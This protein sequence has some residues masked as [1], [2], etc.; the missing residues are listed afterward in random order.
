MSDK[1]GRRGE[2]NDWRGSPRR[3]PAPGITD[4]SDR[5]GRKAEGEDHT[6]APSS[7]AKHS[8]EGLP[9]VP[10]EGDTYHREERAP[11]RPPVFWDAN[12]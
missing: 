9:E 8:T 10:A 2:V 4:R 11:R 5:E 7:T 3:P 6:A 12:L 1:D